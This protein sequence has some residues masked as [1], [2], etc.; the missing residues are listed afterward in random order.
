MRCLIEYPIEGFESDVA[1][2]VYRPHAA[3]PDS[4]PVFV[5]RR[6]W[7]AVHRAVDPSRQGES[8]TVDR[9]T[10]LPA[11]HTPA[12]HVNTE[13]DVLLV[14]CLSQETAEMDHT[15]PPWSPRSRRTCSTSAASEPS[16]PR[17]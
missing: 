3:A 16:A 10:L 14:E 6:P 11:G 2:V 7:D 9:V 12:P 15:R 5:A 1:D 4:C 17:N 8:A 13:R